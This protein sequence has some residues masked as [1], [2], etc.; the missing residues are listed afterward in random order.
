MFCSVAISWQL[1]AAPYLRSVHEPFPQPREETIPVVPV[2]QR[3]RFHACTSLVPKPMT[4]V[5]GLGMRLDVRMRTRLKNGI[6]RNRE[7]PG[8]A[9]NSFFDYSK[10]KAIKSLSGWDAAHCDEHQF[11]AKIKV[12]T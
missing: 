4:M 2:G 9:G 11:C 10:Y 5:I 7:Q 1:N 3:A 8:S 12:S 6:H